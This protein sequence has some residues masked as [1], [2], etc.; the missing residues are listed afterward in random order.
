MSVTRSQVPPLPAPCLLLPEKS[1]CWWDLIFGFHMKFN[2]G[3]KNKQIS[4]IRQMLKNNDGL[5]LDPEDICLKSP[6][7]W[8][9]SS[10]WGMDYFVPDE[11]EIILMDLKIMV[12]QRS[13]ALCR[14]AGTSRSIQM[15]VNSVLSV[16]FWL[17]V[18]PS[19]T[20]FTQTSENGLGHLPLL[21]LSF[22][23]A[24]GPICHSVDVHRWPQ[25]PHHA[26]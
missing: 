6:Q 1:W 17:L 15:T 22:S 3:K 25:T 23:A 9:E 19:S 2:L 11:C 21:A 4:L 16:T 12:K 18:Y 10:L 20:K 13:P 7:N 5:C 8:Q 24:P 14:Q 26:L